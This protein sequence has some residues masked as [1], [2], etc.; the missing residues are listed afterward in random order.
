VD[1]GS[2]KITVAIGQLAENNSIKIWGVRQKQSK[3]IKQGSV[4][5][6]EIAMDTLTAAHDEAKSI[7]GVDVQDVT[8]GGSARSISG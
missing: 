4:I 6:L 1:L 2:H 3:G 7:A 5:N 8:L